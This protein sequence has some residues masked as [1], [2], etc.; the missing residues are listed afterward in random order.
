[1]SEKVNRLTPYVIT[2]AGLR[3]SQL[4][5]LLSMASK[6]Q[7]KAMEEVALNIVKNTV[8]LSEDDAKVC[9]RWRKPLRLLALKRYPQ[10]EKRKI[11]QQGGFIGAILPILASV[12][13]SV[14]TSRANG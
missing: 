1:M 12:I 4:R 14:I 8:S 6:E 5:T 11:L 2:L 13:G 3:P 9:R 7:I 10:K